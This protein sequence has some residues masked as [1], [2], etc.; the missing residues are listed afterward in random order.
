MSLWVTDSGY[1][2]PALDL[3]VQ[4][5]KRWYAVRQEE[6]HIKP[7][8][9]VAILEHGIAVVEQVDGKEVHALL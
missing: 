7:G 9:R 4:R 1:E 8:D 6:R 3:L 5:C 2:A